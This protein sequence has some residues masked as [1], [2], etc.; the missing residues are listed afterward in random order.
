VNQA[1]A[2]GTKKN[3]APFGPGAGLGKVRRHKS[4]HRLSGH[5]NPLA[6]YEQLPRVLIKR[7]PAK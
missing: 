1:S 2:L 4:S 6:G 7:P 3:P 5:S